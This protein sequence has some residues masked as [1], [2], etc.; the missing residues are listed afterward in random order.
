[1]KK[2]ASLVLLTLILSAS[3]YGYFYAMTPANAFI[4]YLWWRITA[5]INVE[6]GSVISH[7]SSIHYTVFGEGR[8]LLMLHGG[9][10]RSLSW[11]GQVPEL[12][13]HG[14]QL[15]LLHSRGHGDSELGQAELSYRTMAADALSV[16]NDRHIKKADI[17][18]WSDGANTGLLMASLFPDRVNRII[19]ISGNYK[20]E[21]LTAA[22]KAENR[23]RTTVPLSIV[24][25][26]WTGAGEHF[27]ELENRLKQLWGRDPV[28][29]DLELSGIASPVLFIIGEHDVI[30]LDHAKTMNRL[31][32]DSSLHVVKGGGHS[33]LM[34]HADEIN[35]QI[36]SFL[37]AE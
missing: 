4:H 37:V 31:V 15:I 19:S 14:F 13:K 2:T 28:L 1:M 34:T 33:S 35:Q 6:R 32:P 26:W 17:L 9:L 5:R 18:G 3:C 11:F 23:S 12:S 27:R 16:L 8:P 36:I 30:T 22:A 10:S 24:L 7:G 29:S 25:R 21:G 20:P